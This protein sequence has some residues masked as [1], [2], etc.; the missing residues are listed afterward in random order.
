MPKR[1]LN[2]PKKRTFIGPASLLKRFTAYFIDFLIINFIILHPFKKILR[3]IIPANQ[4]FSDVYQYL[5]SN[6]AISALLVKISI[7]IGILVVLYFT[8]FEFKTQQTPGKMLMR[9]YII[10]ENKQLSFWNYLISN[11]TFIPFF[12]FILL[13]IIDPVHMFI[14]PKNQRFMEKLTK[15]LVVQKYE[16]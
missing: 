1:G 14:S 15:I 4:S 6:P 2:L 11:I 12:P 10:P 3:E 7:A 16:V 13:W 5:Q 8:Y 9:I